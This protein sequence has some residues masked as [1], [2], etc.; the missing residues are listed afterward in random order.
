M[1]PVRDSGVWWLSALAVLMLTIAADPPG[2]LGGMS[3]V[4]SVLAGAFLGIAVSRYYSRQASEEPRREIENLRE[5]NEKLR[6]LTITLLQNLDGPNLVD[7]KEW[8]PETGEPK[9]WRVDTTPLAM[10]RTKAREAPQPQ[11]EPDEAE[12]RSDR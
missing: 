3:I 11:G 12:P 9:R 8:D 4:A 6:Q 2:V 5:R 10:W 7:I 1:S